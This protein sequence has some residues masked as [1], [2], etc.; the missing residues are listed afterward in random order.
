MANNDKKSEMEELNELLKQQT[1]VIAKLEKELE[2]LTL[3]QQDTKDP[4]FEELKKLTTENDKLK[5]RINI[6][7]RVIYFLSFFKFEI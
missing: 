4:A 7:K 1:T 2:N 5:Y 6:L 3:N